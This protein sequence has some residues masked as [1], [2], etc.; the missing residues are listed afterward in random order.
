MKRGAWKW[1]V[2]VGLLLGASCTA[3]PTPASDRPGDW[4]LVGGRIW[5]S[6]HEAPIE[7]GVVW[8]RGDRIVAVGSMSDVRLPDDVR[9]RDVTG[10]TVTAGFWNSH[11]HFFER[12]W[13]RVEDL[14]AA[15]LSRQL[16]FTFSRYGFTTVFDL[17]SPW[18]NTRQLFRR[19]AS[20]EVDGPH[21]RSVGEGMV[22]AGG[23]P[24]PVVLR[25][26]GSVKVALPELTGRDQA[27]QVARRLL[28][29]GVDGLKLFLSARGGR[30]LLPEVVAAVT[31]V[32]HAAGKP[33]FAHPNSADDVALAVRGGVDVIAHTTPASGPW[34]PQ[35]V[36]EMKRAGVAVTP[37]LTLWHHFARH[38]RI[39]VQD[40]AVRAAVA[41]L[42]AWRT[43]GGDVLFG[44]DLGAV[45]AD[46]SLEYALMKRA[47]MSFPEIL[48]SLTTTPAARFRAESQGRIAPG[49]RADLVVLAGDP[50]G[51][52]GA[53]TRVRTTFRAGRAIHDVD[54]P[55]GVPR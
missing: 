26:M 3:P 1:C 19:I 42:R 48:A 39:S 35:L 52:L 18:E 17:S 43:V 13:D 47:G 24:S 31:G 30:R 6:P 37:T 46:P 40:S 53:L 49:H 38:D 16:A 50:A 51:D 20:G 2:G 8:V 25:M 44:T 29:K 11:V 7:S 14:P 4:A 9:R 41:Q 10:H 15:E 23:R 12:K 33:V 28:E 21:V 22:P 5:V 32:A 45:D 34:S 27:A 55:S 36:R 54:A